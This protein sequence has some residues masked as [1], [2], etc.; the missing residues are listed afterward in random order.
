ME[1]DAGG[2]GG[3]EHIEHLLAHGCV[4]LTGLASSPHLNGR[5]GSAH[6][7]HR[8]SGRVEV[9]LDAEGGDPAG[10]ERAS[11]IRVRPANLATVEGAQAACAEEEAAA[12][13]AAGRAEGARGAQASDVLAPGA[14]NRA[15]ARG[16]GL[17]PTPAPS[18]AAAASA[19]A[20]DALM[21]AV[22]AHNLEGLRSAILQ[23]QAHSSAEAL[24]AA[25]K[26]RDKL[27]ERDAKKRAAQRRRAAN[28]ATAATGVATA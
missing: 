19:E 18:V 22:Q 15:A 25:R 2:G 28:G 26:A 9:K 12:P 5:L 21:A 16:G 3:D 17:P 27:K 14:A 4:V 8:D 6:A 1:G 23:H 7:Y 24:Q 11:W 13:A 10:R 20:D